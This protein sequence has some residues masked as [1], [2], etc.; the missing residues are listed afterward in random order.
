MN[1]KASTRI[2]RLLLATAIALFGSVVAR[3]AATGIHDAVLRHGF[4]YQGNSLY[5][6]G[7]PM[8]EMNP[9]ELFSYSRIA[10]DAAYHGYEPG[11]TLTFDLEYYDSSEAGAKPVLTLPKGT[12]I[13]VGLEPGDPLTLTY[14]LYGY[15]TY[16]RGWRYVQP[17]LR[18]GERL[19]EAARFCFARTADL[20]R[21][22]H[23]FA[24]ANPRFFLNHAPA[25]RWDYPYNTVRIFDQDFY[26]TGTY[27]SPDLIAPIWDLLDTVLAVAG[28]I[29]LAASFVPIIR[30]RAGWPAR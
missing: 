19:P 8:E 21:V 10:T 3:V 17:F 16:E 24:A 4:T 26:R 29:L 15:P 22:A 2:R 23:R 11:V 25:S 27:L 1:G 13:Q 28:L 18:I 6:E 7:V 14:G 12:E 20:E 9:E 30:R 5:R